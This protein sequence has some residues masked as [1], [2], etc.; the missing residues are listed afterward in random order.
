MKVRVGYVVLAIGLFAMALAGGC[1]NSST[2]TT[3]TPTPSSSATFAPDTLWVQDATSRTV[4][5]YKGASA[6]NGGTIANIILTTADAANPDVVYDPVS[7]TLWYPNQT[8]PT[9][10][11][12]TIDLWTMATTRN[13]M[14]PTIT[15]NSASTMNLEGAAVF[16][17]VHNLLVVAHNTG[18]TVDIYS[19]ATGMTGASLPGGAVTLNMTDPAAPGTPRPQEMLY[20]AL[21]DRLFVADNGQVVAKFD[22]FGAWA[23]AHLGGTTSLTS[24]T[25]ISGLSLGNITGLAYNAPLDILFVTEQT[26][27]AQISVVKTAGTWNAGAT[28]AQQL[29]NFTAPK[30]LAYDQVRDLLFVFDGGAQAVFVFPNATTASGSQLVWPNRRVIFDT[31]DSL[32]GFGMTVDTT[33]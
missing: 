23:L 13:G 32:S 4:R 26:S 9:N 7:D 21:N 19:G 29:T 10:S 8:V 22:G 18:N 5:A 31:A 24:N 2:T 11:N 30:G 3:P 14:P 25:Q 17:A 1:T 33:R 27:P 16:D 28:H 6:L 15:V 20:D 12:N